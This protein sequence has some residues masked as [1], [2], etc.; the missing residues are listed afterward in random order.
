LELGKCGVEFGNG[1]VI[2]SRSRKRLWDDRVLS[3]FVNSHGRDCATQTGRDARN[4][5]TRD[6]PLTPH[7][8]R[9]GHRAVGA[10]R[11]RDQGYRD[12]VSSPFHWG[13]QYSPRRPR[14]QGVQPV[15]R[16][17]KLKVSSRVGDGFARQ[18]IQHL[19]QRLCRIHAGNLDR[20]IR[21]RRI[22]CR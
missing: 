21:S 4:D 6:G 19:Q 3:R 16:L 18:L 13:K 22:N 15:I 14:I 11:R 2:D 1:S 9:S 8:R 10:Q 12:Q 5:S 7:L 20:L 17:S